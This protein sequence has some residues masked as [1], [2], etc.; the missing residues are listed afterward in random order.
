[1]SVKEDVNLE[2]Q[3]IVASADFRQQIDLTAA[4]ISLGLDEVEYKPEFFPSLVPDWIPQ[5]W[6][7]YSSDRGD[8]YARVRE[9]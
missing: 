5:R 1:M 8:S 2:V 9:P 4:V 3:N 7:F 6:S